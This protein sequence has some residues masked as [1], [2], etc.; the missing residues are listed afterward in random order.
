ML[1]NEASNILNVHGTTW[2]A[3]ALVYQNAKHMYTQLLVV[4]PRFKK[5]SEEAKTNSLPDFG[6]VPWLG[7]GP[8]TLCRDRCDRVQDLLYLASECSARFVPAVLSCNLV[9]SLER[10]SD[11]IEVDEGR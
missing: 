2:S 6:Y 5:V 10:L 9:G 11:E 7:Y 1:C 3:R 4:H 8:T